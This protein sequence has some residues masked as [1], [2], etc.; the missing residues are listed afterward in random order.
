MQVH[1]GAVG[2]VLFSNPVT[3]LIVQGLDGD[4]DITVASLD[5]GFAATLD[6]EGADVESWL[7]SDELV[8]AIDEYT[9]TVEI[10]G[11]IAT[12]GGDLWVNATTIAVADDVV[13]T[14]ADDPSAPT[15]WGDIQ[16]WAREYAVADVNNLSPFQYDVKAASI[17][18]GERAEIRGGEVFFLAYATDITLS[19]LIGVNNAWVESLVISGLSDVLTAL[20]ALPF[21]VTIKMSEASF[22]AEQDSQ[23]HG[24]GTVGVFVVAGVDATGTATSSIATVGFSYGESTATLDIADGVVVTAGD[25]INMNADASATAAVT[26]DTGQDLDKPG[27]TGGVAAS[28]AVTYARVRSTV[29]VDTGASLT[30][31]KVANVRAIGTVESNP[32][33]TSGTGAGGTTALAIAISISD[34]EITTS[35]DGDITALA[36]PGYTVKFE[37]DPTAACDDSTSTYEVGCVDNDRAAIYVGLTPDGRDAIALGT[38]DAVEYS[39]R[40]GNS[41]GG[42]VGLPEGTYYVINSDTEDGWIQLASSELNS[43]RDRPISAATW[44][45]GEAAVNGN[46]FTESVVDYDADDITLDISSFSGSGVEGF[47]LFGNTFEFGQAVRFDVDSGNG[48]GGLDDGGVY[49][50]IVDTDEFNVSGDTRSLLNSQQVVKLA[51]SEN[52]AKAG[53]FIDLYDVDDGL[54]AGTY[55]FSAFHVLDSGLST[56]IGVIAS[57]DASTG[58]SASAGLSDSDPVVDLNVPSGADSLMTAL[59]GRFASPADTSGLPTPPDGARTVCVGH[60]C[61]GLRVGRPPGRVDGLEQRGAEEQ[62][63]P[64]GGCRDHRRSLDLV[65]EQHRADQRRR[66]GYGGERRD[67]HRDPHQHRPRHGGRSR[68]R[69]PAGVARRVRSLLPLRPAARRARPFDRRRVHGLPQDRRHRGG[70]PVP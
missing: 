45:T 49:Y 57:L 65:G 32:D 33:A 18:I 51:E 20:T 38:G 36:E 41:M 16:F 43:Y 24:A 12:H 58:A 67:H 68:S 30:A 61:A 19:E 8:L 6:V 40:R 7:P 21:D 5:A 28:V 60:G 56:G 15:A 2:L 9:D 66:A 25:S 22:T 1:R 44:G 69:R 29:T 46:T 35:V 42:V 17:T 34:A 37:Y 52:E 4:D 26:T 54:G 3:E 13:V 10:T 27:L 64:R 70:H 55:T 59:L 31:G 14:T 11:G 50:L 47:S 62:R 23:I 48:I 63:G 53:K 39:N